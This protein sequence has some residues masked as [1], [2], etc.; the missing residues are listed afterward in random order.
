MDGLAAFAEKWAKTLMAEFNI[1]PSHIQRMLY[2]KKINPN[3]AQQEQEA[4]RKREQRRMENKQ[5]TEQ[6][7]V[8]RKLNTIQNG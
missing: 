2:L 4:A 5:K 7:I 8:Q 1:Y 3:F 6:F